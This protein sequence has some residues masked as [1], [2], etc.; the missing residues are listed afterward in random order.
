VIHYLLVGLSIYL[1]GLGL[2]CVLMLFGLARDG[3]DWPD[4]F[5]GYDGRFLRFSLALWP[6]SLPIVVYLLVWPRGPREVDLDEE[7]VDL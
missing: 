7:S 2:T 4:W 6:V 3:E 1:A 5:E